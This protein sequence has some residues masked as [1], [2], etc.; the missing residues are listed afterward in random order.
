MR[1]VAAMALSVPAAASLGAQN[2]DSLAIARATES[3]ARVK[4]LTSGDVA[5][6]RLLADSLVKAL[7]AAS[8]VMP[9]ALF[10]KASI[11]ASA[12]DAERDYGLIVTE[13]RFAARVP[14][15]LMRLAVLESAR[16]NRAGAM[17]HL[18][19]FLRDHGDAPGRSRASLLA[20][21]IRMDMND[22]ARGCELLAAA[23]A[24]A[25][26]L[27]RDVRDQAVTAGARCPVAVEVMAARDPAPMGVARA[28]RETTATPPAVVA[29][30]ATRPAPAATRSPSAPATPSRATTVTQSQSAPVTPSR[31]T[32]VSQIQSAP[33]TPSRATAATQSQSAPATP[34]RATTV[35]QSH[36]AAPRETTPPA[37]KP[38]RD[39]VMPVRTPAVPE[40]PPAPA[41]SASSVS[42]GDK[43]GPGTST[44]F[45]VQ[46]AAYNDRPGADRFATVL[47]GRGIAAR[48]E[49][50]RA[51]FRVRAGRYTTLA[52]AEAAAALWRRPGQAAIAVPLAPARP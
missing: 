1:V 48:V 43:V 47:R 36:P 33:A 44:R 12:A 7:P 3:L 2:A 31:A 18:E 41:N 29:R 39:S 5:A 49:G 26:N 40:P 17:R 38:R 32:A 37:P 16:N 15:A 11:A 4:R 42:G 13:H 50:T 35:T 8:P 21:R 14:D 9:E 51:P 24:S 34:S 30:A 27:E 23:Y 28:P 20:G 6:A 19:R 25:T 45:A 22:P 10:A 46:F 52:E